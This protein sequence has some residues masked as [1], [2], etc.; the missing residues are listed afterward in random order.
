MQGAQP[1]DYP[2]FFKLPYQIVSNYL[3]VQEFVSNIYHTIPCMYKVQM[4][5]YA[6]SKGP[7]VTYAHMSPT[8]GQSMQNEHNGFAAFCRR[9]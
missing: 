7:K 9:G 6:Q 8:K 4:P 5:T 3:D 1:F 2:F